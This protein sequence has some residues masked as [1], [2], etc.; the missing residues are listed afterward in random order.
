MRYGLTALLCLAWLFALSCLP[1][2]AQ[3]ANVV[4]N[5]GFETGNFT[6]WTN[7]YN[8]TP[9]TTDGITFHS[10][11]HSA[12]VGGDD[13]SGFSQ[14]IIVPAQATMK[15]WIKRN[16]QDSINYDSQNVQIQDAQGNVL[17]S[18]VYD[19]SNTDWTQITVDLSTYAGQ[20]V[21]LAFFVLG[22]SAG[23]DTTMWVDDVS[24]SG[25][26]TAPPAAPSTLTASSGN[27]FVSLAW[28]PPSGGGL[29]YSVYRGASA[30][31]EGDAPI[32]SGLTAAAY[33]DSGL[34][35]GTHYFYT[36]RAVNSIGSSPPSNETDA[37]P[38]MVVPAA[39]TGLTATR[40]N[41]T[42]SLA[43]NAVLGATGYQVFQGTTPGGE[44]SNPVS[45]PAG[46]AFTDTGLIN[47]TIYYYQV[48]ASNSA[49]TGSRSTE[50]SATPLSPPAA[51]A[52][53]TATAGN[54]QVSLTWT[55]SA[56]A[57]SYNVKRATVSGGPYVTVTSPSGASATDTGLVNGTTYYYVVSA[58]NASGESGNSREA[59]A[60][61][62]TPPSAPATL[63][64]VAGNAQVALT[65]SA[66][67]GAT[68]Y[69]LYR[70]AGSYSYPVLYQQGVTAS[71]YT[72][73]GLSNGTQ[74]VYKVAAVNAAGEGAQS[75]QVSATPGGTPPSAPTGLVART[76][77]YGGQVSLTWNSVSGATS[78]NIYR[79]TTPGGE[80]TVPFYNGGGSTSFY[81]SAVT[82]GTTYYYTVT[83]V[84]NVGEGAA[85]NEAGATPTSAPP[86]APTSLTASP[87][88]GQIT[89]TWT[90]PAGADSY[91]LY[92]GETSGGELSYQTGL[93]GSRYIDT[94]VTGGKR[95][96]YYLTAVN[97][98][99]GS[100]HSNEASTAPQSAGSF[101]FTL[102]VNQ[103]TAGGR[104]VGIVTLSGP[105]PTGGVTV[106]L[107]SGNPQIATL[108]SAAQIPAG[109]TT[110]KFYVNAGTPTGTAGYPTGPAVPIVTLSASIGG[111]TQS[112]TLGVAPAGSGLRLTQAGLDQGFQ[113]TTLVSGFVDIP[114]GTDPRPRWSSVA[115]AAYVPDGHVLVADFYTGKVYTF[116]DQ[117]N[118]VVDL[119]NGPSHTFSSP[120]CLRVG[121]D[122]V[123]LT[124][125]SG[126][127]KL[128]YDGSSK[129]LDANQFP[130]PFSSLGGLNGIDLNPRNGHLIVAQGTGLVDIDP[131]NS[132]P[133]TNFHPLLTDSLRLFDGVT[134]SGDG[135]FV[136]GASD[137]DP[138]DTGRVNSI[139]GYSL[140]N[141]NLALDVVSPDGG[142]FSPDGLSMG[143]GSL[144][145]YLF[146]N[147]NWGNVYEI[148]LVNQTASDG[149]PIPAGTVT[150]IATGGSR[151]DYIGYGSK[152]TLLLSQTDRIMRL[153]PPP[154]SDFG[155]ETDPVYTRDDQAAMHHSINIAGS[156]LTDEPPGGLLTG[157]SS[158]PAIFDTTGIH[159]SISAAQVQRTG[160]IVNTSGLVSSLADVQFGL[161]TPHGGI[162]G[163]SSVS[164]S[165]PVLTAA[166]PY[167]TSCDLSA[168]F[169]ADLG[170]SLGG[171]YQATLED[172]LSALC[173]NYNI[174]DTPGTNGYDKN[175]LSFVVASDGGWPAIP[176]GRAQD[177]TLSDIPV[178][179]ADGVTPNPF[180]D[181]PLEGA[182]DI[183]YRHT[184]SDPN[185]PQSNTVVDT[186]IA[187][188]GKPDAASRGVG[189]AGQTG[190][191]NVEADNTGY[192]GVVLS[193]PST[194]GVSMDPVDPSAP[195]N[196]A[197]S[198]YK[199]RYLRTRPDGTLVS[200]FGYFNVIDRQ[201]DPQA[202][203]VMLPLTL[204]PH[205]VVGG[206][207][208]PGQTSASSVGTITLD[209][210]APAG[211]AL[212]TLRAVSAQGGPTD[213]AWTDPAVTV[214]AGQSTA[215]FRVYTKQPLTPTEV[216]INASYN[217]FRHV[218]LIVV[219]N[220]GQLQF[221]PPLDPVGNPVSGGSQGGG[222][223]GDP[224]P[225]GSGGT[226][227]GGTI[228]V[229]KPPVAPT[230]LMAS[231][232]DNHIDL[233]WQAP[234]AVDSANNPAAAV[235]YYAVA[236]ADGVQTDGSTAGDA[237]HPYHLIYV[238]VPGTQ[239]TDRSVRDGVHYAY[240]VFAVN[241]FGY[242]PPSNVAVATPIGGTVQTPRITP[243]QDSTFVLTGN[244][245][246][247]D[248]TPG[249]TIHY[250]LDGT[251]PTA[252]SPAYSDFLTLTQTTTVKARAFEEGWTPS[253]VAAVTLTIQ[254]YS[255]PP[256]TPFDCGDIN[257]SLS[258]GTASL[259][260]GQ[261][262]SAD[263]YSIAGIAGQHVR[264]T[265]STSFPGN[266]NAGCLYLLDSHGN[267]I[268][269]AG[270]ASPSSSVTLDT[271][272]PAQDTYIIEVTSFYPYVNAPY[273]LDLPCAP[274]LAL[275]VDGHAV[276]PGDTVDYGTTPQGTPVPKT[277]TI[278]NVGTA[279]LDL[280]EVTAPNGFTP[281]AQSPSP[282]VIPA[283]S[284]MAATF[285]LSMAA[286]SS[287]TPRGPVSI[288]Y[289]GPGQ[290]SAQYPFTVTGTVTPLNLAPDFQIGADPTD[291]VVAQGRSGPSPSLN[292][293]VT[294]I[295]GFQSP[296]TLSLNDWYD[297][298]ILGNPG[299]DPTKI[300]YAF[301]AS[302]ITPGGAAAATT[303]IFTVGRN[304]P[305]G[306]YHFTLSGTGPS[307][308]TGALQ[309]SVSIA[310][311]VTASPGSSMEPVPYSGTPATVGSGTTRIEAENY[312][313]GGEG[314]AFHD[315]NNGGS[316][317]YRRD[318]IG[319]YADGGASNGFGVGSAQ[320]REWDGYT[321]N[322]ATAGAYMLSA[323][324][325]CPS[326]GG[327][328]HLEFGPVGQVG[329]ANI[330][331]S[332]PFQVPNTGGWTNYADVTASK[333]ILPAGLV[334][335]RLV[336]DSSGG[337]ASVTSV[338]NIDYVSLTAGGSGGPAGQFAVTIDSPLPPPSAVP[339]PEG[340]PALPN[341]ILLT[342]PATVLGTITANPTNTVTWV[343][344][345]RPAGGINENQLPWI[346]FQTG[347]SAGGASV[348]GYFDTTL[349]V[350]GQYDIQLSATDTT[351][352][353]TATAMITL[354]VKGDQKV[355]HFTQS[356]VD[357]TI[358]GAGGPL[359]IIRTYDSNDKRPSD[360]GVGWTL[361]TSLGHTQKSVPSMGA[362]ET[363]GAYTDKSSVGMTGSAIVPKKPHVVTI[364]L[365]NGDVYAFEMMFTVD[366]PPYGYSA[367]YYPY[368]PFQP[369]EILSGQVTYQPLPGNPSKCTLV[370]HT[371][372]GDDPQA[373][374]SVTQSF[375]TDTALR[376]DDDT[377]YDRS[378]FTLTLRNGAKIL[379]DATGTG[380]GQST[381]LQ[382]NTTS[383]T[384]GTQGSLS[385]F[386]GSSP[387]RSVEIDRDSS[388]RV[389]QIKDPDGKLLT[390][391]YT[392][393]D[394]TSFTDRAKSVTTYDYD[395]ADNLRHIYAPGVT[396]G[397]ALV[398]NH[399]T[400]GRLDSSLDAQG[401]QITYHYDLA[402][403]QEAVLDRAGN[404]TSLGYDGY[405]NV[406]AKTQYLLTT[407]TSGQPVRRPITA[408][409]TF[410][411]G[412]FPD[413][414]TGETSSPDAR[415]VTHQTD[416]A[417]TQDGD[418]QTVTAHLKD[419]Q[420]NDTEQIVT[421]YTYN[422]LGQP[423]TVT[424][425]HDANNTVPAL[426]SLNVYYGDNPQS[427]DPPELQGLLKSTKDAM[428]IKD[429]SLGETD[430]FYYS[431]A[432]HP[433]WTGKLWYV[434]DA[435][436]NKTTYHY[437][438]ANESD[439]ALGD[440]KDV[441]DA[442]LH[443]T[444][445]T[446]DGNGNKLSLTTTRTNALTQ[447]IEPLT[448][449][450]KYDDNDHLIKT[451]LPDGSYTQTVYNALGK[452]D[453]TVGALKPGV[454]IAEEDTYYKY[455]DQGRLSETDYPDG[456][457]TAAT[458]D[459]NGNRLTSTNRYTDASNKRVTGYAYD[460]LGRLIQSGL[461]SPSLPILP[462]TAGTPNFLKDG[463]GKP[464]FTSTSYDDLGQVFAETD[465]NGNTTQ[466]QYDALG[467][468]V[469]SL[470]AVSVAMGQ[471]QQNRPSTAYV[472]NEDGTEQSVTDANGHQTSYHY[473]DA[474]R[475]SQT[476]FPDNTNGSAPLT[477]Y[478]ALGRR[479]LQSDAAGHT[480]EYDYNS[481]G[482]LWQVIDPN[483]HK[484]TFGY[485]E[486]GE[487]I[488]Q[489]DAN[490]HVTSFA[491]DLLGHLVQKKLPGGQTETM[492]YDPAGRLWHQIGFNGFT[493]TY[494]YD[495][496][497]G[498]L[499]SKS[500]DPR[501]SQPGVTF[502]Y[503]GD[504]QRQAATRGGLTTS[505]AYDPATGRLKQVIGPTGEIDYT[506]DNAGN[507]KSV[508]TTSAKGSPSATTTYDYDAD[509]RLWHVYGNN[510]YGAA[511]T[512]TYD[513]AG[514]R[515]QLDR[516]NGVSTVYKYDAQNR[517]LDLANSVGP[518]F[519]Y[520]LYAD[521]KRQVVTERGSGT[522]VVPGT[523]TY[524]YTASGWLT[525][526]LKKDAS[527]ATLSDTVYD[528][529][530]DQVGNRQTRTVTTPQG[531]TST[532]YVYDTG[533]DDRLKTESVGGTPTAQYGYD[534][535]G[536]MTTLET[537][538]GTQTYAYD[539]E[540][541]LTGVE[542]TVGQG[543][544]APVAAYIY[545]ADGSRL[546]QTV[547]NGTP[548]GATTTY[549][550]DTTLPFASVVQETDAAGGVTGYTYG[551]DLAWMNRAGGTYYY[552][553][554]GLGSTRALA[555]GNGS[556]TDG[557]G[558]VDAF[559]QPQHT[560]GSTANSF[561]FNGQQFDQN[562]GL[563]YLR[564]RYYAPTIGR[565]L[566]Q[567]PV[568]GYD[569]T[570]ASLH[571]YL[572]TS[573]EP[574]DKV[575]PGGEEESAIGTE[576]A[577]A[578]S[579]IVDQAEAIVDVNNVAAA[580]STSINIATALYTLKALAQFIS[581]PKSSKDTYVADSGIFQDRVP[582][583][584]G[585]T[586]KQ[587]RAYID[588]NILLNNNI[589]L[590]VP[591]AAYEET[592]EDPRITLLS[593][594]RQAAR[595]FG[596]YGE[597]NGAEILP[598]MNGD[599]SSVPIGVYSTNFTVPDAE[600]LL[601]AESEGYP[602]LTPNAKL[603]RQVDDT[604][605]PVRKVFF[606]G[607][608]IDD[609]GPP[610]IYPYPR[611]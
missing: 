253:A 504:G 105:A 56:D 292:V 440:L 110:A 383:L 398:T 388:N 405:G 338:A 137:K 511:A 341:P 157:D 394:L 12:Y 434:Q 428:Q 543:G 321:L 114:P 274:Q 154:G 384:N 374:V 554:D 551:D 316:T 46:T 276:L 87:G 142:P 40:G 177:L 215:T 55:A 409:D 4:S 528:F 549:L 505:Y 198:A 14:S 560:S 496:A 319:I 370:G 33:T 498:R 320:P 36:V 67:P 459:A 246:L 364:T 156:A 331:A 131:K 170:L 429:A 182:W 593:R 392:G 155:G 378:Q 150:L 190:V 305:P 189:F 239:Y 542:K 413:K 515:K 164:A 488:W 6:G 437:Y 22:D 202:A 298:G 535:A 460:S 1:V 229:I 393:S 343:L 350:N 553:D 16:T 609:P 287:G 186:V 512:Y 506:Y 537:P 408:T 342:Q 563:Y 463:S 259:L 245:A 59:S 81:D 308:P 38:N 457:K 407:N 382:H 479:H 264:L 572:Y 536:N 534:D 100:L 148:S 79:S 85:S 310:L 50:A 261:F 493:T 581:I 414:K 152:G 587:R 509:N 332:A 538:A 309:H 491:Y 262:F 73:T 138:Y 510:G 71:T 13:A 2:L 465:E 272:L 134:V 42:I 207:P 541:H 145:G 58:V 27:Q 214:P 125:S 508:K 336:M 294:P 354:L 69:N 53:L 184:V 352:S 302:P 471:W 236:R 564:A 159:G 174:A 45:V 11:S 111:I 435:L 596:A 84:S 78:Y 180:A 548:S 318:N 456:S 129:L 452:V 421:G 345:Y 203:P 230:N 122:S 444:T 51:P 489:K 455:D 578:D 303:L 76:S 248:G 149:T 29:T 241:A 575:D 521:G 90:V 513:A 188:S 366:N 271:T 454:S 269:A 173:G 301:G 603:P 544:L 355:G 219:S 446:Y 77:S 143:R 497:S 482:Q 195:I 381:D 62:L 445:F 257:T 140:A 217:G 582:S 484:T 242:S 240:I 299:A 296:V 556:V 356:F 436:G 293:T 417:Y 344:Q 348:S 557:Y 607:V 363:W 268:A 525:E 64:A 107:T 576:A 103:V 373:G 249:S 566:S 279:E 130:V 524:S 430:Y 397:T 330:T 438:E 275:S 449:Y 96:Y 109:T 247:G 128:N 74:Y 597:L 168:Q 584:G 126:I 451:T 349:L 283:N 545:D 115:G 200:G 72:D 433:E 233:H 273:S 376:E 602:V 499:L 539:F 288:S 228:A 75:N 44:G 104:V 89:L 91:S 281:Q 415:G 295:G 565:F 304:V 65:W 162:N 255:M 9:P 340:M 450:Y 486:V 192:R 206:V 337:D 360:F 502:S 17:K 311:T 402:S 313:L 221:Q 561:L 410:S 227:G 216:S 37:T 144:S 522:G 411:D 361:S 477:I 490:S 448:T 585:L 106:A 329:G 252:S 470:D 204:S 160:Q 95:Y 224:A 280:N 395:D 371:D 358:P 165:S 175:L 357:L 547:P 49:G 608:E 519:H 18:V 323:H 322:I 400:G 194:A 57:V 529:G 25:A 475:L 523:T 5:G 588:V 70:S 92:R 606:G 412:A 559:G 439:G 223:G 32:A 179:K 113:L 567:D 54:T 462:G 389:Y 468:K 574:V 532:T 208:A 492:D 431:N 485:D 169:L 88:T 598:I 99:G 35:N 101:T 390:Y 328:F 432:N 197:Y 419:A 362:A 422:A 235:S 290:S 291:A 453:H 83:A 399:Y 586:A 146:A 201:N 526:E 43:W 19:C 464:I 176:Q 8:A 256:A 21:R 28:T 178:F 121:G 590:L 579:T 167:L 232:G 458:Y 66:V 314:I 420:G 183:V 187:S 260:R 530:A 518:S 80:G 404:Q 112:T 473:D 469:L 500:P 324:V 266:V 562:L 600:I 401:K 346:P 172:Q 365:P 297:G 270:D 558:Y 185:D 166:A 196:A 141:H 396:D 406:T 151:G 61:P 163:T 60:Q 592:L 531:S 98:N 326:G 30:D 116:A 594:I 86:P 39:P 472:Y 416:Y 108:P 425:P 351:T 495:P 387:V 359:Q 555:D 494:G 385:S 7:F 124:A 334:W 263:H 347:T 158:D 476:L 193:V 284:G 377:V 599:V 48:S 285:G 181:P 403:H 595:I 300:G 386:S 23:D 317:A 481:L 267:V 171:T 231:G 199:V 93:T 209:A 552:I 325:A 94:G 136:Y 47:G 213:V 533:G 478:D 10:G 41:A 368:S 546:S 577:I 514:N 250:T 315:I 119:Q 307:G 117:D 372:R 353:Q 426:R 26:V 147:S 583:Q 333:V 573:N 225:T 282:T 289:N 127:Y 133:L 571:R 461:V 442:N 391:G 611:K 82:N 503:Y 380:N 120:G 312:D 483:G 286:A 218:W 520:D 580:I 222:S 265:L 604:T 277:Y 211:G 63:K 507:R 97:S 31:G 258:P 244:V 375:G 339:P 423:L 447:Q 191:W 210:P 24:V 605:F 527:N 139:D 123:Y 550:V 441:Y 161:H 68:S 516:G 251:D 327:T 237:Q 226:T 379:V 205:P 369:S 467:R 540:N 517:L 427:N 418:L 335:M 234:P 243:S 20:T 254:P 466:S 474:G 367:G 589:R 132:D 306:T 501:L 278:A 212:V 3:G 591:I 220:P 102:D 570:P 487:K 610:G 135:L 118:Q 52:G 238:G 569:D 34:T 424:A 480:T 601:A 443:A 568:A 15:F 153:I